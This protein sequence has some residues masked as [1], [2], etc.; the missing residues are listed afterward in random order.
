VLQAEREH[1]WSTLAAILHLGNIRYRSVQVSTA[2]ATQ[3]GAEMDNPE[4]MEL[5]A[6][7]L[8]LPVTLMQKALLHRTYG[9]GG[10]RDIILIPYSAKEAAHARDAFAKALYAGLF[11]YL[12]QCIN[13]ALKRPGCVC[14]HAATLRNQ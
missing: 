7:H 4:A 6:K 8:R 5:A 11:N 9:T 1:V 10:D 3:D 2:T 13:Q 12:G 14:L